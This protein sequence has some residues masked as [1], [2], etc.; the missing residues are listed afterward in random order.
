MNTSFDKHRAANLMRVDRAAVDSCLV[1]IHYAKLCQTWGSCSYSTF[2]LVWPIEF[3]FF[4]M[5]FLAVAT[6]TLE[7]LLVWKIQLFKVL[8]LV[9]LCGISLPV[10]ARFWDLPHLNAFVRPSGA[11][12]HVYIAAPVGVKTLGGSRALRAHGPTGVENPFFR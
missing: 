1:W 4:V 5:N 2:L 6:Y 12:C 11:D 8:V 10:G 3:F 7:W 9:L